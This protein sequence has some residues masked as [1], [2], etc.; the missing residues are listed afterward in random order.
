M[1]ERPDPHQCHSPGRRYSFLA[2]NET[3][4]VRKPYG[5]I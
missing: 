2:E 3:S 1:I 5:P 4:C